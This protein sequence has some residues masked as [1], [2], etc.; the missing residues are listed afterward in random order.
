VSLLKENENATIAL[1]VE[2][3]T[4]NTGS[5]A[6]NK[7]LSQARANAVV[8]YLKKKG[9]AANRLTAKGFGPENPIADNKTAAG[10]AQ[11]RR[12]ELKLKE[13]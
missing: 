6:T 2:G 12:V 13:M 9:I 11:N 3:Y 10:R 4:D 1:D 8:A 7:K 5:A